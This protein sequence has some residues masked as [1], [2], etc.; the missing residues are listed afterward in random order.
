MGGSRWSQITIKYCIILYS[1]SSSNYEFIR[2]ELIFHIPSQRT[3]RL[4]IGKST[5]EMGVTNL[6]ERRLQMEAKK[7]SAEELIANL[8][9]DEMTIKLSEKY[10]RNFGTFFGGV[11]MGG[12]VE[13]KTNELAN[14]V[15]AFVLSGFSYHYRIPVAIFLV[16][17]LTAEEQTKLTIHV[18]QR[19]EVSGFNI[20][21]LVTDNLS[22]NVKMFALLNGGEKSEELRVVVPHPVDEMAQ[23]RLGSC[24]FRPLVLSFDPCH[25]LK[26][27]INQ[28][29]DRDFEI[30]GKL[31][32]FK[33][34][35]LIYEMQQK[36]IEGGSLALPV[37]KLKRKHVMPHNLERQKVNL[38]IDVFR[39][40]VIATIQMRA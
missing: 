36:E 15:L 33:P 28:G 23:Q 37:R 22:T 29:V 24:I 26:N 11:D 34:L 40:D 35:V 18:I 1:R 21:R 31:V 14:K 9:I 4:Y 10:N 2:K 3:L 20:F 30:D 17:K 12:V 32:S 25:G 27:V 6:V 5:G 13:L 16:N 7:F 38:V 39:P 19:T 8:Q